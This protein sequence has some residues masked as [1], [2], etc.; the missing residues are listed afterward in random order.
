MRVVFRYGN[1][2]GLWERLEKRDKEEFFFDMRQVDW[3][4]Y[5]QEYYSGVRKYLLKD[6][7][8]TLPAALVKW[9]M[10]VWGVSE[11]RSSYLRIAV[12]Y[13]FVYRG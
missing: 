9:R 4:E 11:L 13:Y 1:V 7:E 3:E 12:D 10:Y 5:F 6:D 8:D 2:V